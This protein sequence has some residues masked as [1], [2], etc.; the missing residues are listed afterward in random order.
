[1]RGGDKGGNVTGKPENIFNFFIFFENGVA[2]T[3]G[4]KLHNREGTDAE[5]YCFLSSQVAEDI[6]EARR[7]ELSQAFTPIEWR[8]RLRIDGGEPLLR[9]ILHE[10]NIRSENF[11]Y[12]LTPVLDGTPF[13]EQ[14]IGLGPFRGRDVTDFGREGQ[15]EDYLVGYIDEEHFRLGELINDDYFHA[16]RVLF[17]NELYVSASK[18]LM[19]CI[20]TIA[21]IE[22]GDT[23]GNFTKWLDRYCELTTLKI[24]ADELW[25][26]RNSVLHMTSLDS[27]KVLSGKVARIA[28][29]V[30]K[31]GSEP[32]QHADRIK[33]F[34]LL[35]LIDAVAKGISRWGET[36]N[37]SPEKMVEF[38]ARYDTTISDA[39]MSKIT[40]ST[41]KEL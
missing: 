16:I 19:C 4:V 24:S 21:F 22:F 28:P 31:R 34:N 11:L 38:I 12:C 30:A 29:Y 37:N 8:A 25:E 18:L 9:S 33:P 15:M 5:K 1:M 7:I 10:L 14:R 17:Q 26:Y 39:R 13:W 36:Y 32:P 40:R 20:D 41:T 3:I 35:E 6:A 2:R 23:R 27:K